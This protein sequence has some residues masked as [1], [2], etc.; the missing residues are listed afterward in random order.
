MEFDTGAAQSIVRKDLWVKLSSP[1]LEPAGQL[2]AYG[3]EALDVM[4]QCWVGIKHIR[5]MPY[6]PKTNGLAERCVQTFKQRFLAS[7]SDA[8]DQDLR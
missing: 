4:G 6:H 7:Q 1:R 8:G 3:G 5:T 2:T